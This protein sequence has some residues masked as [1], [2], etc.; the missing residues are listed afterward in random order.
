M[1]DGVDESSKSLSPGGNLAIKPEARRSRISRGIAMDL[2]MNLSLQEIE[3]S[4]WGE[5]TYNSR[6]ISESHRLRRIPL[7]NLST[8]DLRLLIGQ[9]I[10]TQH[11]VPIA[12]RILFEDPFASGQYY[13]GD[14]LDVALSLPS[15]FWSD[16]PDMLDLLVVISQI[17]HHD[18]LHSNSMPPSPSTDGLCRRLARFLG[19]YGSD[20]SHQSGTN[21]SV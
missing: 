2:N 9:D 20:G 13:P 3:G 5:P 17:A 11:I 1:V 21:C 6:V 18:L 10:G 4:D 14:L 16:H 7:K 15:N 19:R 8:E 12:L